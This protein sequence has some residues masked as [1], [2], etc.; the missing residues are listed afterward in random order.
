M[1]IRHKKTIYL[2]H[3]ATTY[4][5][6][7]VIKAMRPFWEKNFGN[8]SSLYHKGVEAKK[9]IGEARSKIA[10]L[11]AARPEEIVFTAGGTESVN[12]AIFG[13]ARNALYSGGK[14]AVH[15]VTTKIEHHAVSHSCEALEKEGV[16]TTYLNVDRQGFISLTDLERA[17]KPETLLVSVM[18]ANNE[19]GTIEPITQIGRLLKKINSSRLARGLEKVIFHTDACQAGGVCDLNVERLGVDLMTINGS[20]IYGPKQTG[21]LY[22]RQGT[23]INPLIYGGGQE[24][25][26]RSGTENVPGMVGLSVA[27]ELAQKN[28]NKENKRLI[29]LRDKLIDS[30]LLKIPEATLNGPDERGKNYEANMLRL[31]N[32]VNISIPGVE[33]EALLLYLDSEGI[34]VSTGSACNSSNFNPSHVLMAIGKT[35][36]EARGTIRITL[37]KKT[38]KKD[39]DFAFKTILQK[40]N[41]LKV[42]SKQYTFNTK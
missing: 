21:F 18:Y 38:N 31:P 10:R 28:R 5:D 22:I 34:C 13:T 19:I 1:A 27:L 8:P 11:L 26:L 23:K 6:P 7:R 17:I 16:S 37:G 35:L 33:G 12:M 32:N 40:I 4:A 15:I 9:A 41:K 25:G 36:L 14:K 30:L 29:V 20:K 3:A 24:R 39:L 2:D 42:S